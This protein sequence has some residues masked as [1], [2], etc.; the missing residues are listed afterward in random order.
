MRSAVLSRVCSGH[1]MSTACCEDMDCVCIHVDVRQRMTAIG[2]VLM[3]CVLCSIAPHRWPSLLGTSTSP[4][5]PTL[6]SL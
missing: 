4:Y 3:A 1:E 2:A 5:S 6:E